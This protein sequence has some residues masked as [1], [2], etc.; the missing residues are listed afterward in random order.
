MG[1]S[2]YKG[3]V[4]AIAGWRYLRGG[5]AC[6]RFGRRVL[7]LS[8]KGTKEHGFGHQDDQWW[9]DCDLGW[10]P[11][12]DELVDLML[13]GWVQSEGLRIEID[14][15]EELGVRITYLEPAEMF[16][17][18]APKQSVELHRRMLS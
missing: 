11:H 10:L 4:A 18:L 17:G 1:A 9:Y 6:A 15:A 16:I 5:E 2:Y 13:P 7:G 14:V 12:C 3:L 8:T